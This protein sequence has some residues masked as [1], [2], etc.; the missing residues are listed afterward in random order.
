MDMQVMICF[1][2]TILLMVL[3]IWNPYKSIATTTVLGILLYFVTGCVDE[4]AII[5]SFGNTTG[6]LTCT[7][8]VVSAG[9]NKTQFVRRIAELVHRVSN[10]SLAKV[11]L[12]YGAIG[13]I[14]DM[15]I[16]SALAVFCILSPMLAATVED[17][18]YSP[19]K[20]MFPFAVLTIAN[21]ASLPIG[22]CAT[23]YAQYNAQLEA[24]GAAPTA[25]IFDPMIGRLPVL[26]VSFIYCC[27]I[28]TKFTPD[29]PVVSIVGIDDME[30]GGSE[31]AKKALEKA[32]LSSFHETSALVIFF[33][34]T[35]GL[36]VINVFELP[37][38]LEN[39][40]ITL[41]GALLMIFT[42]VLKPKEA[43]KAIPL[44]VWLMFVG[45]LVM[46]SALAKTGAGDMIG[47]AVASVVNNFP[48]TPLYYLMLSVGPYI[49]TNFLNNRTTNFIFYPIAIQ[50]CMSLGADPVGSLICVQAS[51]QIAFIMPTATASVAYCM[52]A[53]GYDLKTMFKMGWFPTILFIL[54][55]VV[56]L[57]ILYP[58]F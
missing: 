40:N 36:L 49:C 25:E 46:A 44:W 12:G 1:A 39:W 48:I 10:G 50:I 57:S 55:L 18:G 9:F 38:V 23:M 21:M 31:R 15:F 19:S 32:P 26:I 30:G 20:V 43:S 34:V 8:F 22:G 42:G 29:R 53:G 35:I 2:I 5:Q 45:G 47:N 4:E 33:G 37:F 13:V 11:M 27:F 14:L 28:A 52:G 16:P 24:L 56:W 6:L 7:M 51:T 54:V 17:M 41:A 58:I 3:F